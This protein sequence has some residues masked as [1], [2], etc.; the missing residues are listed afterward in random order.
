MS[1]L[2]YLG[3]VYLALTVAAAFAPAAGRRWLGVSATLFALVA[4]LLYLGDLLLPFVVPLAL[5][6]LLDPLLDWLE[7]QGLSRLRAVIWVYATLFALAIAAAVLVLPALYSEASDMVATLAK[8]DWGTF[9]D[10]AQLHDWCLRRIEHL[11][12]SARLLP[13]F[14]RNWSQ[15]AP[16]ID[17]ARP[18][19]GTAASWL[20]GQL[21]NLIG[22][23]VS[24]VSG[25]AWLVLLPL[26]L[27]YCLADFDVLRRRVWHLVPKANQ[28]LVS[29]LASSINAALGSYARGYALLCAM[30][31]AGVTG[32]L[33]V[34]QA[35]FGFR[36]AL[37]LGLMAGCTYFIPFVGGFVAVVLS[38]A[39]IFFTG[40]GSLVHA[41]IGF[42]V[43]AC[44]SAVFDNIIAPRVIGEKTGLHPLWV[45]FG[46][47]VGGKVAGILGIVLSTPVL[48]CGRIVLEHFNPRLSERIPDAEP[49]G[50]AP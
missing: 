20:G 44:L 32:T 49:D 30:V 14:E 50:L 27:W 42:A 23:T 5:A 12:L 13:L 48:V 31:G 24:T 21:R 34:L 17:E 9:A 43:L 18:Y 15:F 19:L 2:M 11:P 4:T 25:L 33:L 40:D 8:V 28:A 22:W 47:L 45:M 16:R 3:L 26:N 1:N 6:Y 36:Y 37:L 41:G 35:L 7:S 46:L 39:V 29:D 10:T 38:T